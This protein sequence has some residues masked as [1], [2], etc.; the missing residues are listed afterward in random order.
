M[1]LRSS[2]VRI[3]YRIPVVN[4]F[5]AFLPFFFKLL[6]SLVAC[7]FF[8]YNSYAIVKVLDFVFVPSTVFMMLY[9][10]YEWDDNIL[11][12]GP[13]LKELLT[14]YC[15]FFRIG[16]LTFGGGYAMMPMLQKEVIEKYRWATEEEVMDYYAVGQCL[17]GVIA[18]NTSLFIGNKVRGVVGG[19]VAALG[20]V[21][22][23]FLI[24]ALIAAF[25]ST[26]ADLPVVVH[27]FAGIRV[28]VCALILSAIIKM[29]KKGVIDVPTFCIFAAVFV[30]TLFT[31]IS[32]ILVVVLAGVIGVILG[33]VKNHKKGADTK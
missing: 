16:A 23:S 31:D 21:S 14:L 24:I 7:L 6:F 25:L 13:I 32:T 18:V 15:A 8:C 26:F 22:P 11:N 19:I 9:Y 30:S 17:P 28:G 1:P 3:P 2:F 33:A 10:I 12:G 20:V 27:A 4:A 29:W 5:F